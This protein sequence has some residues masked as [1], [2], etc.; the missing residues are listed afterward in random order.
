MAATPT[1][2][3]T[4][5]LPPVRITPRDRVYLGLD[6]ADGYK[7]VWSSPS[8]SVGLVGPPRYGKTSG[9]IIPAL[10]YWSGPAVS[11]TTRGDILRFC[12]NWRRRVAAPEGRS[13]STTPSTARALAEK[14]SARCAGHRW[15]GARIRPCASGECR[16]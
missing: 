4:T 12:G 6:P 2:H 16:A 1:S 7:R 15:P 13:T 9:I 10:L 5:P 8:D 3:P 14:V 11:T